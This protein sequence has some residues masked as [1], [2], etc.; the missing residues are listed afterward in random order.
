M[1]D[2]RSTVQTYV[3]NT[4]DS[5]VVPAFLCLAFERRHNNQTRFTLARLLIFI[6]LK[7]FFS[8]KLF[9]HN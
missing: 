9:E 1:L 6:I 3:Q 4:N 2:N 7:E 8:F 5:G